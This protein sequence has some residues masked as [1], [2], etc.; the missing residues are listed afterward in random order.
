MAADVHGQPDHGSLT[1][2]ADVRN[3][4]AGSRLLVVWGPILPVTWENQPDA[5][6]NG[7]D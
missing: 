6:V 4:F 7:S 2:Q 5:D 1:G 3:H